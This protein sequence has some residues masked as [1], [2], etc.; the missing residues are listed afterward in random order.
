M[1]ITIKPWSQNEHWVTCPEANIDQAFPTEDLA[2]LIGDLP[3][4][5]QAYQSHNKTSDAILD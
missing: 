4:L 5:I 3:K 1:N 2:W